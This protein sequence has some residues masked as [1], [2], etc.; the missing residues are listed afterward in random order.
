MTIYLAALL[1]GVI[2]GLRTMTA[3]AGVS[4]AASLGELGLGG[5]R[6]AF[7]GSA[8]ATWILTIAAIAELVTD[9]LPGTP[10]RKT[11][12]QFGAR[13]LSGALCGAALGTAAGGSW[14]IAAGAGVVGAIVGTLA[15]A[16]FRSGLAHAFRRDKPAAFLEDAVAIVGVVV[17]LSVLG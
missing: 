3:L 13:I 12:V 1:I 16:G 15:G 11:P 7:L 14:K 9:Q 6:L 17:V 4:W 5:T 10:S 8:V 2:A